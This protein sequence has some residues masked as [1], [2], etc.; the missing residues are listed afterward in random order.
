MPTTK[1][2]NINMT[3]THIVISLCAPQATYFADTFSMIFGI[4]MLF[5]HGLLNWNIAHKLQLL[6]RECEANRVVLSWT[7]PTMDTYKTII[8]LSQLVFQT[9]IRSQSVSTDFG[10]FLK[11]PHIILNVSRILQANCYM[12][13]YTMS[14]LHVVYLYLPQQQVL[15]HY[16]VRSSIEKSTGMLYCL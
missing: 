8:S 11:L 2:I 6:Q 4:S 1:I 7:L 9:V 5:K 3:N 16:H 14:E 12:R 10:D 13:W 15:Q